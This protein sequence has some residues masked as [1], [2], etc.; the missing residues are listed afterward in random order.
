MEGVEKWNDFLLL[1]F[2][3]KTE[4]LLLPLTTGFLGLSLV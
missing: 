2:V 3:Q 1:C 4:K